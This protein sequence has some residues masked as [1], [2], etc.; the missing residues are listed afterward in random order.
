MQN[1]MSSASAKHGPLWRA[2]GDP[3]DLDAE[4]ASAF[5]IAR[6]TVADWK[7]SGA[8][9]PTLAV[10]FTMEIVK[11]IEQDQDRETAIQLFDGMALLSRKMPAP[12]SME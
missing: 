9:M 3:P 1:D 7:V 12:E 11:A 5:A 6:R 4:L 10:A 8:P 2:D